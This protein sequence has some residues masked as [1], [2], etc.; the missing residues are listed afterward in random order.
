[1]GTIVHALR[2]IRGKI[3]SCCCE[4]EGHEAEG[5]ALNLDWTRVS[6]IH[7]GERLLSKEVGVRAAQSNIL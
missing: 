2:V 1:M 6:S 4:A 3:C 5:Q 7:R